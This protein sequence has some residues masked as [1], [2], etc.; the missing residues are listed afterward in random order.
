M[1]QEFENEV[2]ATKMRSF[3]ENANNEN[4]DRLEAVLAKTVA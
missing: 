1:R 2:F 3:L 4:L